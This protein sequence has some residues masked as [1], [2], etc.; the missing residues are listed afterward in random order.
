MFAEAGVS[1]RVAGYGRGVTTE[2]AGSGPFDRLMDR[3][4][5]NWQQELGEMPGATERARFDVAFLEGW[6]AALDVTGVSIEQA[7]ERLRERPT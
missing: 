1:R 4:Y 5:E 7:M 2:A 6:N 3:A